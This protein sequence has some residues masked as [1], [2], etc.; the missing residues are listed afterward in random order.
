MADPNIGGDPAARPEMGD[1]GDAGHYGD[2][3]LPSHLLEMRQVAGL[4]A[5]SVMELNVG[6]F[7]FRESDSDVGF[8]LEVHDAHQVN[9]IPG[10]V[11]VSIDEFEIDQPTPL[12]GS[13]LHVGSACFV[14]RP[15]R[16][17]VSSESRLSSVESIRIPPPPI[18]VPDLTTPDPE[19]ETRRRSRMG[20]IF[21]RDA[22]RSHAD[23]GPAS[24][25]FLD[26]IGD[27][28]NRVAERQRRLHPDPEELSSRLGRMDPGLW[29]RGVEHPMF[30]R[31][32]IAYSTIPWEPRFD[33]PERIPPNLYDPIDQLSHLPWVPVTSNL[34]YGPLG[35]VGGRQAALACARSAVLSLASMTA[36]GDIEFSIVT[37]KELVSDWEWTANLPSALFPTGNNRYCVAV[38]DALAHFDSAGFDHDKVKRNEMGLIVLGNTIDDLPEYCGTVLQV[39]PDGSCTVTNHL[40]EQ[41][42][43][44][45]IGITTALATETAMD[46]ATALDAVADET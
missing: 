19:A 32:P 44:T 34:L 17:P 23:L 37:S 38:A 6:T 40:G 28:R 35:I 46:I 14:V 12:G 15:P 31:F 18:E 29:D 33:A 45:P 24:L 42:M 13:I 9:V 1:G 16:P 26:T 25:D 4:T 10:S 11:K 30:A 7:Q 36:V 2:S 20:A 22:A 3:T 8:S 21:S 41:V 5:G 43:G 39:G 27:L